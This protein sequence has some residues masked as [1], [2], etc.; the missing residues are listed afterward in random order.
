MIRRATRDDLPAIVALLADDP[1]GAA[2]E[3]TGGA[4]AQAYT[5]AFEAIESDPNICLMVMDRGGAVIGTLQLSMTPSLSRKG[6]LRATIE[7]VR[8]HADARGA[9]L[10]TTLIDWAIAEARR[11]GCALVQL[12]SDL[13]RTDAHRFYR[14]LGFQQSHAGFKKPL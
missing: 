10:G 3:E 8:I 2:R 5:Q 14:R 7:A 9:G 12:T 4:L 11:R 13:S 6:A 1:L